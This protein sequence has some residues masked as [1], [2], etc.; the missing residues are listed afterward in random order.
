MHGTK[1]K[2]FPSPALCSLVA[3]LESQGSDAVDGHIGFKYDSTHA[4]STTYRLIE[5]RPFLSCIKGLCDAVHDACPYIVWL[6]Q[7]HGLTGE[8]SF[9]QWHV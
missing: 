4:V 8:L 7:V 1:S 5:S 9:H 2:L 6:F 3:Q